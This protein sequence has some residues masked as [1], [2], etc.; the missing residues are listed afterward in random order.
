MKIVS[1]YD[2]YNSLQ[3]SQLAEILGSSIPGYLQSNCINEN[4]QFRNKSN[5]LI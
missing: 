4:V 3:K 2:E 1:K 5:T